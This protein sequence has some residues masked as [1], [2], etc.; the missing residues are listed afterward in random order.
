MRTLVF[1]GYN[2]WKATCPKCTAVF[3]YTNDDI[4][5][6]TFL[7]LRVGW[8]VE[9]VSCGTRID[10]SIPEQRQVWGA[11]EPPSYAELIR[12]ARSLQVLVERHGLDDTSDDYT[13]ETL[14]EAKDVLDRAL[15][16]E[17]LQ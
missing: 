13:S 9:C 5:R 15:G 11:S 8:D 16:R 12:T 10:V 4:Q 7:L 3:T 1:P 17:K 2:I 6:S 14:S